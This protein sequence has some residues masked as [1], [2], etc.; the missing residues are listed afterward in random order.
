MV[1]M[2]AEITK[3]EARGV[4]FFGMSEVGILNGRVIA[5][6]AN[7][8]R[9]RAIIT[10]HHPL[11]LNMAHVTSCTRLPLLSRVH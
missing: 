2:T 10:I 4:R 5:S 11:P 1:I 8:A 9:P 7:H 6:A 3:K